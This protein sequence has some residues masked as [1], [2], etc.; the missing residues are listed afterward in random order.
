[1]FVHLENDTPA[2]KKHFEAR[3]LEHFIKDERIRSVIEGHTAGEGT[4]F[5]YLD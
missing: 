4:Q 5:Q 1:M 3:V 2:S